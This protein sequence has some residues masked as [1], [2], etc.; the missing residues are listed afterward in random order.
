MRNIPL[1]FHIKNNK[2][3]Y[4]E[5][6]KRGVSY[7]VDTFLNLLFINITN[8]YCTFNILRM[9]NISLKRVCSLNCN[10]LQC[11]EMTYAKLS[12]PYYSQGARMTT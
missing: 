6:K 1:H 4:K 3:K 10:V 7:E 9:K 8:E 5:E 12:M 11:I 2:K